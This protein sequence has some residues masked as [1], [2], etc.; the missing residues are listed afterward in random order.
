MFDNTGTIIQTGGEFS[1]DA[2]T[3]LLNEA[4]GV[5]NLETGANLNENTANGGGDNPVLANAGTFKKSSG[6]GST[7][8]AWDLDN[9]GTF[10]VDAGTLTR[11]GNLIEAASGALTGG[12]WVVSG[13]A[14]LTL[15]QPGAL[16]TNQADVNLSGAGSAFTNLSALTS[17]AG[18]LTLTSGATLSAGA[19]F[20][21]TGTLTIGPAS[22]LS[23]SGKFI[24][25]AAGTLDFQ[26][27]GA[28][29]GGKFGQLAAT[30]SATLAG[31]LEADL[32]GGYSATPGDSFRVFSDA[33][34]SGSFTT[35]NLPETSAAYF[36]A[37]VSSTAAVLSAVATATNLTPVSIGNISPS[38]ATVGQNLSVT[39]TI[40]NQ[41]TQTTP[42]SSWVDSVYLS[43]SSTLDGSAVLLGQVTHSGALAAGGKYQETVNAA[44]PALVEGRYFVIVKADSGDTVPDTNRGSSA[45][46]S[47]ATV[48]VTF[49]S[50]K[51]GTPATGTISTGQDQYYQ[52]YL[53]A[54]QEVSLTAV[55][56]ISVGPN[57]LTIGYTGSEDGGVN[58]A[59]SPD[60]LDDPTLFGTAPITAVH[61]QDLFP[62]NTVS[63]NPGMTL[64]VTMG[65]AAPN[66]TATA[67][68]GQPVTIDV[69]PDDGDA[70]QA[71]S[72]VTNPGHGSAT[73]NANSTITYT[74]ATGFTGT[75][76]FQ[77]TSADSA[78]LI[79]TG[80]VTITVTGQ[81]NPGLST[82]SVNSLPATESSASFTVNWSGSDVSGGGGIASYDVFVSDDG[83]PFTAFQTNTTQTSATF[84]GVSGH[85]Y[86]FYSVA[87]DKAG[88]V[89]PTPA[90]AQATTTVAVANS[91]A[92]TKL[93][94]CLAGNNL[95]R[96]VYGELERFTRRGCQQHYFVQHLLL[97]ERWTVHTTLDQHHA[98]LV[99][100]H[101]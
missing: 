65:S 5:Y 70:S 76:T 12:T 68:A 89:Q 45:L 72:A 75:D 71:V 38:A 60:I 59:Y 51:L 54:G 13:G 6:S 63:V 94:E 31:A 15:Q 95:E 9:T 26:L 98:D 8:M 81:S 73:I 43:Q 41:G 35:V 21:N 28:P 49:P 85:K 18:T 10:E 56:Q 36:Q 39:F 84:N 3:T 34:T 67:T 33:G 101:G 22:T 97:G 90:A 27:G 83:G 46:A 20:T 69:L 93:G 24:Q 2:N 42:V 25:T 78:G 32:E 88:K 50:L 48:P 4:G 61:F 23:V 99:D 44:V 40:Q 64:P 19:G 92:P 30:G 52:V 62:E 53:P 58:V 87:T 29:S 1:L 96:D 14:S 37:G 77:Y 66:A 82:S 74:P 79:G 16:T 17:S 55:E 86:G 7:T 91:S 80:T 11:N 47:S 100:L 57:P